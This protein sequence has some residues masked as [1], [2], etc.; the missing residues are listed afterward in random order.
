MQEIKMALCIRDPFQFNK[1][2]VED[3]FPSYY[4]NVKLVSFIY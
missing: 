4:K 2:T 1:N 3:F